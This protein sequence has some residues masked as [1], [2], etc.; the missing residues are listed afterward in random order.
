MNLTKVSCLYK[1]GMKP[2][3]FENKNPNKGWY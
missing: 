2:Y 3:I 1:T